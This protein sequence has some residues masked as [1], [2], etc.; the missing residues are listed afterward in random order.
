MTNKADFLII[1]A[2]ILGL[3]LAR[4]LK[5][6]H[7]DAS[8]IILEKEN[9]I[10]LHASG[11]NSGVLHSGIY[12]PEKSLKAQLCL[13]GNRKL[14]AY[15]DE[16]KLPISRI[17]KIILPTK[18]T[19]DA[20]LQMLY[21]R[22]THNGAN[23]KLIDEHELKQIEPAVQTATGQALFSPE[24][25]VVDSKAI[26]NHLY[27]SLIQQGVNIY[28]NNR[29]S[30]INPKLKTLTTNNKSFAYGHLFNTAGLYADVIA[31]AC[32]ITDRFT[33][34]P[35]KGLYFELSNTS[36]I[37]I[38]HLIY[39][40]PDMNV[41]FLGVHFTKSTNGRIYVGPTA[42]PVFGRENYQGLKGANVKDS[43]ETLTALGRQYYSNK[44]GFRTYTHQEVARFIPKNFVAAA[45]ALIPQLTR[46]DL[47]KSAKVGIR[48]QLFD[49]KKGELVMDFMIKNTENETHVL[50][51]VSPGFT[52][53][54]SFSQY[55][56]QSFSRS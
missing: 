17:G 21:Q 43:W 22:A 27:H 40:V 50:N 36:S 53:A 52:S 33:M 13:E 10:G 30:D 19:D 20:I 38:N 26:L 48:A 3:S 54:F 6:E 44:Q 11:R 7:P 41:P 25:A 5:L 39:P 29:C 49:R 8:I 55:I 9:Q 45:Q 31:K 37:P 16:R 2:G 1:G 28:L 32:G 18:P 15:C 4:A 42:I 46:Q 35:F 12:Y 23:V 56:V 14:A 47:K 34:I 51:A 24:T